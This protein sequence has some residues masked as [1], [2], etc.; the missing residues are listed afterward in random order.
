MNIAMWSGPRNLSTAMMY[1][2]AARGDC[3]VW[4]EPFYAAYLAATGLDHPM[5][6]DHR[7]PRGRPRPGRRRL[8][9]PRHGRAV[10]L[11]KTHDPAHDPR[12]RP[13]LPAR[14]HQCVPDPPSGPG[15]RLLREKARRAH[16]RRHRLC[17]AGRPVR[18]GGRLAGPPAPGDRQRRY[19][20]RPARRADAALR[21]PWHPYTD[22]MLHWPAGPKPF[23]GI[24]AP[25]WYGAV[26]ASSGFEDPEGRCPTCRPPMPRWS[27]RRCRTMTACAPWHCKTPPRA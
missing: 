21:R 9:R 20:R 24:W 17:P 18:R 11:S 2:F 23:D 25:H 22:A 1:A 4:D 8:R 12:V 19:P 10:V 16:A 15:R 5:R 7:H 13:W 3:A 27:N 14:L 6:A 26:H